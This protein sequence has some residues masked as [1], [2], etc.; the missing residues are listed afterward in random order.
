MMGNPLCSFRGS[1]VTRLRAVPAQLKIHAAKLEAIA[2]IQAASLLLAKR[3]CTP[4]LCC[5]ATGKL[6]ELELAVAIMQKA[7]AALTQ[8]SADLRGVII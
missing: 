3:S 7:A 6:Q 4:L 2:Y 5:I 8:Q 1:L